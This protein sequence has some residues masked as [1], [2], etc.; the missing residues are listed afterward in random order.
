MM[1]QMHFS[2]QR[3]KRDLENAIN[4]SGL[5]LK[6]RHNTSNVCGKKKQAVITTTQ[7]VPNSNEESVK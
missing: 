2:M 7:L 3:G 1:L 5:R 6:K 4:D